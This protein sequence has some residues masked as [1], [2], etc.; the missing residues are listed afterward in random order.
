M[1]LLPY[2]KGPFTTT[3]C[4]EPC[5]VKLPLW[6]T[7]T[8]S[9]QMLHIN[10]SDLYK[11]H[12]AQCTVWFLVSTHTAG[13]WYVIRVWGL[14]RRLSRRWCHTCMVNEFWFELSPSCLAA[15]P[16]ICMTTLCPSWVLQLSRICLTSTRCKSCC[17]TQLL[18][19]QLTSS[20]Q[21]S[22]E[23]FNNK[24]NSQWLLKHVKV[25]I[26][27]FQSFLC[28]V[29]IMFFCCSFN[30]VFQNVAGGQYDAGLPDPH[31]D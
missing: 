1:I 30:R 14:S 10:S 17:Q 12:H 6:S 15:H 2:L 8:T 25:T 31:V 24:S 5:K 20:D 18:K 9:K 27:V 21:V 19:D 13:S 4:W 29:S 22:H 7:D 28:L 26:A 3:P 16:D 11:C 23:E